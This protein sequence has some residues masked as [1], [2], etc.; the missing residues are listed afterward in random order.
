M[1]CKPTHVKAGM[2]SGA[3]AVV[4]CNH[5]EKKPVMSVADLVGGIAGG[6]FG[7][8]WPD[9]VDPSKIGGPNHRSEG[10]GL[11]QNSAFVL[12]AIDNT[13]E[14]RKKCFEKAA[15]FE[16]KAKDIIDQAKSFLWNIVAVFL[17]FVAGFAPGAL[18]GLVSHLALDSF[19]KKSLPLI[20]NRF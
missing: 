4:Y 16:L 17:R 1:P 9:L 14:F 12:W 3:A 15:E 13:Q 20:Y 2:I 11:F 6:Y 19:T 8:R 10:H 7:G 18:A 5:N